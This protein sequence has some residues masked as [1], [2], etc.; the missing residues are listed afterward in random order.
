[1]LMTRSG[2][3]QRGSAHLAIIIIVVVLVVGALGFVFWNNFL[4]KGTSS[5]AAV[6]SFEECKKQSGSITLETYPEQCQTTDGKTF[7][8]PSDQQLTTPPIELKMYCAEG[9]QLCFD[10][11]AT[12]AVTK[13]DQAGVEQPAGYTGDMLTVKDSSSGI[14]LHLRSGMGGIGGACDESIEV[15]VYVLDSTEIP[16]LTGFKTDYS[17]DTLRVARVIYP[18]NDTNTYVAALYVTGD[19]DYTKKQTINRCGIFMSSI[20][21]G[22]HARAG[23]GEGPGAFEFALSG[24]TTEK[25]YATVEDATKAFE[26]DGYKEAASILTS[27]RYK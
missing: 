14:S 19:V 11:P 22:R 15:P 18:W 4:S 26:T 25:R 10:Y 6:T 9:E 16:K 8:G 13:D 24:N 21:I 12:W 5:T 17:L 20:N 23:E 1:M 7:V 3:T 2:L 27:L